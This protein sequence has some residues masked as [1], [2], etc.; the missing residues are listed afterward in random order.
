ML[1]FARV[2]AA[3][4]LA[5]AIACGSA[6]GG[7]TDTVQQNALLQMNCGPGFDRFLGPPPGGALPFVPLA[8]L[9]TVDNPVVAVDPKTGAPLIRADLTNYIVDASAAI[10]L[11]KAF[12]WE[13]QAGSD[14]KVSCAT[15]HF[16]GGGDIRTKNQV[17]PGYNGSF[18]A[19]SPNQDLAAA[20]FPF[21]DP[22]LGRDSDNIV[23]SQGVR[24][25][26]FV[27]ISATGQELTAPVD[28][29]L[30]GNAR[31]VTGVNAPSTVN[32]VFNHRNFFNGRAQNVFNGVNPFGTRDLGARVWMASTTT[33]PLTTLDVHIVNA[34][35]ASQA[36]GPPLNTTEMSAVGRTFP[37]VGKKLL[38]VKPLGLQKVDPRDSVL[39][40]LGE[41]K[42]KGLKTTYAAMIQKAFNPIFWNSTQTVS[43]NGNTYTLMQANF[44]LFWGLAI[45][46]YEGTL[47][48]NDSPMDQYAA[49]RIFDRTTGALISSNPA[50]L[51][52]VVTRLAAQGITVPLAAGGSRAVTRADIL[53]GLDLFEKPIPP[54]AVQG[55]PPGSGVGCNQCHVGAETTGASIRNLTIGVAPGDVAFANSHYDLRLERLLMGVRNPPPPPPQPPP[56]V[57]FGTDAITYDTSTYAITPISIY[58]TP[59][60]PVAMTVNVYD[61]GW[62]N[63]GVRPSAEDLGVGGLDPFGDPLSW[64][65]Y[66][67]KTL[68]NPSVIKVPGGAL[69]CTDAMGNPVVP[70]DAPFGSPFV[71]QVI[72]PLDGQP[73]L[74]GGLIANEATDVAGSFNRPQLRNVELSGPSFH[75]GGKATLRQVVDFYDEG[76]NFPNQ[77]K[78]PLVR[79]LNLTEDQ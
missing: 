75:T 67:Q 10:Q 7:K 56:A 42:V 16:Q 43:L 46:L 52:P 8:S 24:S 4:L 76:G 18:D 5:A 11:G 12:F 68:S 57:P 30:Y 13:M 33:A 39:G 73:L 34:A 53:L 17:S 36:V 47:V 22:L 63:L 37:D 54:P 25:S 45:M 20:D 1:A 14:N 40:T 29:P 21:V 3:S 19:L 49:S 66:F 32:S 70:P 31:Q 65:E 6:P 62:Y 28:N 71:G 50:L 27:G 74:S 55:L 23:G 44:S 2:A 15:C 58:G 64:T 51:D 78:N 77:T 41:S 59:V 26:I 61:G 38:L 79:P 9:K 72:N 48:A 35:L 60:T 69:A